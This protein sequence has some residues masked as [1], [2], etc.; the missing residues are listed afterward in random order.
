MRVVQFIAGRSPSDALVEELKNLHSPSYGMLN[1]GDIVAVNEVIFVHSAI[2]G[3]YM[4]GDKA[5]YE[6]FC[7]EPQPAPRYDMHAV[8]L[9]Y[10]RW[11]TY[12]LMQNC[13]ISHFKF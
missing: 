6:R 5:D 10:W 8:C 7:S 3:S 13:R 11:Y 4:A 12:S 9:I 1:L 2:A